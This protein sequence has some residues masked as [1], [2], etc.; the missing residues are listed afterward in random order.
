VRSRPAAGRGIRVPPLPPPVSPF[1]TFSAN[2]GAKESPKKVGR[3]LANPEEFFY[4]C[5][6]KKITTH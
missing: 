4:L 6:R 1:R 5:V 2:F 3:I